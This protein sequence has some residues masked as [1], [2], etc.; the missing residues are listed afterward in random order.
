MK[1]ILFTL[2]LSCVLLTSFAQKSPQ[3]I[4]LSGG[5]IKGERQVYQTLD[6][7]SEEIKRGRNLFGSGWAAQSANLY[8]MAQRYLMHAHQRTEVLPLFVILDKSA[9]YSYGKGVSYSDGKNIIDLPEAWYIKIH[10]QV[11]ANDRGALDA[12]QLI[13]SEAAGCIVANL[14]LGEQR[15]DSYKFSNKTPYFS[16]PTDYSTALI[17]GYGYYWRYL[18][19]LVEPNPI[20]RNAVAENMNVDKKEIARILFGYERDMKHFYRI[21]LYKFLMPHWA[22]KVERVKTI[23]FIKNNW[24]KLPSRPITEISSD[25][26]TYYRDAAFLPDPKGVRNYYQLYEVGGVVANFFGILVK[27]NIGKTPINPEITNIFTGDTSVSAAKPLDPLTLS[28][29]K[30][31]LT[32][33]Q[34]KNLPGVENHSMGGFVNAYTNLFQQD[35]ADIYASWKVISNQD[36]R[37]PIASE[38]WIELKNVR[39]IN[40]I[41]FPYNYTSNGYRFNI[42]AADSIDLM[43]IPGFTPEMA[44]DLIKE[45]DQTG[46]FTSINQVLSLPFLT[47]PIKDIIKNGQVNQPVQLVGQQKMITSEA[48]LNAH[49]SLIFS[50]VI[51]WIVSSIIL[52]VPFII[53]KKAFPLSNII[54]HAF[55]LFLLYI[56]ALATISTG[57]KPLLVSLIALVL[58]SALIFFF[59]RKEDWAKW[60]RLISFIIPAAVIV[61]SAL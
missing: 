46:P 53:G 27:S 18:N 47:Q 33:A 13:F 42:N 3:I 29:I 11:F 51:L 45:R 43:Q 32:F 20:T 54:W 30:F 48:S 60:V 28:N 61:L 39:W 49:M 40:D 23:T 38:I 15:I 17:H 10:P 2:V 34:M 59:N 55:S 25:K 16:V 56:I 19:Y 8:M 35:S 26:A 44:L 12:P 58:I 5:E 7:G 41:A 57:F 37:Q 4:F 50:F 36:W 31:L 9:D 21:G 22:P 1:K 24:A 6:K 14:M 52:V